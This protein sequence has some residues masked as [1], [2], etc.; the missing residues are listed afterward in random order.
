MKLQPTPFRRGRHGGGFPVRYYHL[1]SVPLP[2]L[3]R[4]DGTGH[5]LV[6]EEAGW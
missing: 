3:S 4:K 2:R 1:Y 5:V 6:E